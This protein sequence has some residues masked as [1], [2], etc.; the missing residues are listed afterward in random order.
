MKEGLKHIENLTHEQK[1]AFDFTAKDVLKTLAPVPGSNSIEYIGTGTSHFQ[2]EPLLYDQEGKPLVFSDW[3]LELTHKM[4]GKQTSIPKAETTSLPRF[5]HEKEKYINRS[6]EI[7][8]NMF[9]FSLDFSRLCPSEGSFDEKMMAEYVQAIA[10]IKAKG[11]EPFL[12]LHHFTMPKYLI[13]TDREGNINAGGWE[14]PDVAKNFRFYIENV[15]RFLGDEDKIRKILNEMNLDKNSQDKFL[16]EGIAQYFMTINEPAATLLGSYMGGLFPPFKK[17]AIITMKHVL[18]KM[19]EANRIASNEI[20]SGLKNYKHEPQVGV[21]YNWQYY[22]G[23]FSKIAQEFNEYYTK[24]FEGEGNLSDFLGLHYYCRIKTSFLLGNKKGSDL[25]Y[26]DH[27]LFGDI[28]PAGILEDIKKINAAYPEKQIFISEIGFS[29]KNDLRRPYWILETVHY[30]IEAKKMGIPIK[31]ILLWTLVNNFEWEHG[32]SQKFGLFSESE[33]NTPLIN[34]TQGIRS[35]EVW[36]AAAKAITSPTSDSLQKLQK[37][38]ETAY[39]Q[40]KEA[41]GKF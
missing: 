12:T 2:S 16:T 20:K 8:Q 27:P 36:S 37:I 3:E 18:E 28:Y 6:A 41:G 17:G 40:Y 30:I 38:Y 25:D 32:T 22:E 15:V 34:S 23:M 21:G 5:L 19:V 14:H 1:P 39:Q 29:D 26:G 7:S 4:E 10:L 31:G 35:W 33:L 9:R 24:K 11:Q 13:G